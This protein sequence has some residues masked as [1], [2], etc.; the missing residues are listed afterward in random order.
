MKSKI[1]SIITNPLFSGSLVMIIGSNL[2]SVV[3][4]LY[5]LVMAPLLKPSGYGELNSIISVMGLVGTLPSILGPVVIKYVS[6]SRSAEEVSALI[7]WLGNKL[8]IVSFGFVI[9]IVVFSGQISQFLRI[10]QSY[11][12]WIAALTFI[13][14]LPAYLNK[15]VL[16]G[17]LRFKKLVLAQT[18]ENLLKLLMGAT[19]VYWGYGVAGALVGI[20][21]AMGLGWFLSRV[22]IGDYLKPVF[23]KPNLSFLG[24][25]SLFIAVQAIALTSFYTTDMLL[26]KH[27]F[28]PYDAGLYAAMSRLGQAIFFVAGPI[29]SVMFALASKRQSEGKGYYQIFF[30]SFGLTMVASVLITLTYALF[31][32]HIVNLLYRKDY[33]DV[34]KL[35]ARFGVFMS[36]FTLSTLTVNFFLSTNRIR[37]VFLA[38]I[39]ALL[40]VGGIWYYHTTLTQVINV[41]IITSALLLLSLSVYFWYVS[42]ARFGNST[43][44]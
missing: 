8:V 14:S 24:K 5:H 16:Q 10:E 44:I 7:Y 23:T 34:A 33:A 9:L 38:V 42:K 31:P 30:Y 35:L 22:Y 13:P 37:V 25:Y 28:S 32:T 6:A 39:A 1:Q 15:S 27:F 43:S 41:S 26:V 2:S 29:G 21:V 3:N 20:L 18:A 17:L 19:L 40:Q 11:L 4:Y 12:F 36:L